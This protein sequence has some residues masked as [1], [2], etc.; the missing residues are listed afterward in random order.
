MAKDRS[1]I[2]AHYLTSGYLNAGFRATAKP[3]PGASHE[4][5]VVYQISEGP[6]VIIAD[7]ITDGRPHTKQSADQSASEARARQADE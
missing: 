3:V 1:L 4:M 7:V 2:V 5:D 6:Q